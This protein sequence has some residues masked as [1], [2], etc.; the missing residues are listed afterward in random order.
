[1]VWWASIE[2]HF[3]IYSTTI[4]ENHKLLSNYITRTRHK[5]KSRSQPFFCFNSIIVELIS[6][7]CVSYFVNMWNKYSTKLISEYESSSCN[8]SIWHKA[9]EDWGF[10]RCKLSRWW[11]IQQSHKLKHYTAAT[12]QLW[13]MRV[14]P[15]MRKFYFLNV[16][17]CILSYDGFLRRRRVHYKPP[18][19]GLEL[20]TFLFSRYLNCLIYELIL[21][22]CFCVWLTSY[23]SWWLLVWL[24]DI[25]FVFDPRV[26]CTTC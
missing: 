4:A 19:A 1:M 22:L 9:R 11:V 26:S 8:V 13:A 12:H 18:R 3:T 24:F 21:C 25:I 16:W 6:R 20:D 17:T 15:L 7:S 14:G 10:L 23:S 2:T 5:P